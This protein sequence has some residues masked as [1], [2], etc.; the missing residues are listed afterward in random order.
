MLK[1][2]YV[3]PLGQLLTSKTLGSLQQNKLHK[4][5]SQLCTWMPDPRIH[6]KGTAHVKVE[7]CIRDFIHVYTKNE[8]QTIF[9]NP[10]QFQR[11]GKNCI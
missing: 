11:P 1:A 6:S 5:R 2:K 10:A 7:S 8:F 4:T 3:D 9:P